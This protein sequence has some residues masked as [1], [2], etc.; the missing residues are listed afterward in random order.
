MRGYFSMPKN[1]IKPEL[2]RNTINWNR[3][4]ELNQQAVYKK[5]RDSLKVFSFLTVIVICLALIFCL[6][7]TTWQPFLFLYV[8]IL[9]ASLAVIFL[10]FRVLPKKPRI[11]LPVTYCY[12][13]FLMLAMIYHTVFQAQYDSTALAFSSLLLILPMIILDKTRRINC[14]VVLVIIVFCVMSYISLDFKIFLTCCLNGL[15]LSTVSIEL[16]NMIRKTKLS[17]LEH[18]RL[19]T[20]QRDYDELTALPNRRKLFSTFDILK[21]SAS[22]QLPFGIMMIDIDDFKSYNDAYGHQK[23]DECLHALGMCFSE[24]SK[25]NGLNIFRFGGEE[26]LGLCLGC[27]YKRTGQLSQALIKTVHDLSQPCGEVSRVTVSVGYADSI[28]CRITGAEKVIS[29]ADAALYLAKNGG[30]NR[31]IGYLDPS[32]AAAAAPPSPCIRSRK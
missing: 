26:F 23:G 19:L 2:S 21:S 24:F 30:K 20:L 4:L 8:C 31:C 9:V 3:L 27:D 18:Q 6:L 28:D 5:N 15:I 11:L 12:F 7:F 29:A 17:D 1:N 13:L 32:M 22:N 25:K 16:G 14:F 10:N